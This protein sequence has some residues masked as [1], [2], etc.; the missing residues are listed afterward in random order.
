[1]LIVPYMTYVTKVT[2]LTHVGSQAVGQTLDVRT[3]ST[4]PPVYAYQIT[5]EI[6]E[7]PV[8]HVSIHK[9]TL[10]LVYVIENKVIYLHE[11]YLPLLASLPT[12]PQLSVGCDVDDDCPLYNACENRQCIDPCVVRD[13]CG[14]NAYCKVVNHQPVCTCPDGYIGSPTTDC[15]PR[16]YPTYI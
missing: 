16:K 5:L 6:Q 7:L 9:I 10:L 11:I 1:M 8:I 12:S 4:V 13:P 3:R 15:R 2:V 14:R